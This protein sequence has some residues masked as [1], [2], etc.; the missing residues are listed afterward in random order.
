MTA[1]AEQVG[2]G[3]GASF[4]HL[5]RV[6]LPSCRFSFFLFCDAEAGVLGDDNEVRPWSVNRLK[7]ERGEQ[8]WFG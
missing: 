3:L 7:D 4:L 5:A 2:D 1:W 8:S 6:S